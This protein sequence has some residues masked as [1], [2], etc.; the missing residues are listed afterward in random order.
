[1]LWFVYSCV[2]YVV[3][4]VAFA[5]GANE[6]VHANESTS[7]SPRLT[8]H[9]LPGTQCALF[10]RDFSKE[11]IKPNALYGISNF[12]EDDRTKLEKMQAFRSESW[13][14]TA[15]KPHAFYHTSRMRGL[16]KIG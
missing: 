2:F 8:N 4:L 9:Y 16:G 14:R 11:H 13:W 5:T 1:M 6:K 3:Y 12:F 15:W 10:A 7:D